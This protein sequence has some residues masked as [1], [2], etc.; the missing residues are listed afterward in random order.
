MVIWNSL[1]ILLIVPCAMSALYW[2]FH[3][4]PF[5]SFCVM[6]LAD[7]QKLKWAPRQYL[8]QFWH[9]LWDL[10]IEIQKYCSHMQM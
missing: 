1:K 4:N 5:L 10:Q 9:N 8:I 6:L 7:K 2:K 3:E